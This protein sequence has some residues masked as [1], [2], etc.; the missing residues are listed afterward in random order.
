VVRSPDN[1]AV[2]LVADGENGVV[3]ESTE[4]HELAAA[5]V[6]VHAAGDALRRSTAE[7]FRRNRARLSL[8]STLE[9]LETVYRR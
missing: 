2:E 6:R 3:V 5:I 4:P 9:K 1:A 7:W 8:E